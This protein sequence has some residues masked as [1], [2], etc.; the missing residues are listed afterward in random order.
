MPPSGEVRLQ[1][2]RAL[3]NKGDALLRL[4]RIRAAIAA[5]RDLVVGH[6]DAPEPGSAKWSGTRGASG[7]ETCAT[8]RYGTCSA[9]VGEVTNV[10]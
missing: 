3:V 7:Q 9:D 8:H 2:A 5:Y 1:L 6:S 4:G 10:P